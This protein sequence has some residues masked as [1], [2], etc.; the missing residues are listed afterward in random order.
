[1]AKIRLGERPKNFKHTVKF[2]MLDG[3]HGSVE[4]LYKYRTKKEFG[5][6][7][8]SLM[9]SAKLTAKAEEGEE[10]APF[11]M[12]DLME[13]TAGGN[14]KYIMQVIEGW[15]LDGE[16]TEDNVQAIADVYPAAA[17]A[18]METYRIACTEGRLGN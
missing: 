3:S 16:L 5:E 14:A 13:K 17:A 9:E 12:A 15:N 6:F 1:M 11:S 4:V 18:I 8:D 10:P 2:Q 7:I